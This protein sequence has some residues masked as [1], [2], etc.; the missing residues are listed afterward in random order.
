MQI[1]CLFVAA[2]TETSTFFGNFFSSNSTILL[3]LGKL[4]FRTVEPQT[5]V[6]LLDRSSLRHDALSQFPEN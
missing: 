2:A 6:A 5:V 1:N 3:P 4:G